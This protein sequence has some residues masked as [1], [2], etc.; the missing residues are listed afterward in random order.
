MQKL[1]LFLLIGFALAFIASSVFTGY[2]IDNSTS[3]PEAKPY[4]SDTIDSGQKTVCAAGELCKVYS[5]RKD[6]VLNLWENPQ[7]KQGPQTL[8]GGVLTPVGYE[9][10]KYSSGGT[11][12]YIGA[13]VAVLFLGALVFAVVKVTKTD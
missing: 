5:I 10:Y 11:S 12:T 4:E 13:A 7:E 8:T 1:W 2:S 6:G 3:A 9:C